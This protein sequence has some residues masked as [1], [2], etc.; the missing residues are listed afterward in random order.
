MT[1]PKEPVSAM[2]YYMQLGEILEH[3]FYKEIVIFL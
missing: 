1:Q 2:V 3:V